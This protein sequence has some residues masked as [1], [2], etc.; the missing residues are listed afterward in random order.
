MNVCISKSK[1]KAL[2]SVS[3][4]ISGFVIYYFIS[5]SVSDFNPVNFGLGENTSV[6]TGTYNNDIV[7][8]FPSII[9]F[10]GLNS[11]SW[12]FKKYKKEKH[13]IALIIGASQ[14][15]AINRLN[16]G[17]KLTV[18]YLNELSVN[19]NIRYLQISSP[20]ANFFDLFLLYKSSRDMGNI[21]DYL[22]L[23]LVFDDLREFP[24]QEQL[25]QLVKDF[26]TTERLICAPVVKEIE[27]EKNTIEKAKNKNAIQRNATLNTPQ[28]IL[29]NNLLILLNDY[30]PGY[31]YRRNLSAKLEIFY[32]VSVTGVISNT[33]N[34]LNSET[35]QEKLRYPDI[36][37]DLINWNKQAL[38]SLVNLAQ[39]DGCKIILYRQPIR[40]T[41][42][43]FYHNRKQYD[44]FFEDV[45]NEYQKNNQVKVAD[46]E[47]IV[48][49]KY[50]GTTNLGEPDVFHFTSTGHSL[51]S[52]KI[53]SI[54]RTIPVSNAL[55]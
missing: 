30:L 41:E 48:P 12:S 52:T 16:Q 36:P 40:P 47:N 29:E 7:N 21:P 44:S 43:E 4:I 20:N 51:L 18:E 31:K 14:I 26:D 9:D 6:K 54:I 35:T 23:P 45:K 17:D 27:L 8:T 22:I 25:I 19:K 42:G 13:E 39:Y 38:T 50:W 55:Q 3:A 15:H 1:V 49:Q 37:T 24:V 5:K 2:F 11:V 53:D 34:L 46:F 28:E 32:S 10:N 33:V